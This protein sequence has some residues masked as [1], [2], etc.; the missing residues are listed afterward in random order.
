MPSGKPS[1]K[2][3]ELGD[4]LIFPASPVMSILIISP[5][6]GD[7]TYL[8]KCYCYNNTVREGRDVQHAGFVVSGR[9]HGALLGKENIE[10][11]RHD[12]QFEV[13]SRW[14]GV[15]KRRLFGCS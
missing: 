14:D 3:N 4:A 13:R 15:F 10:G 6:S 9:C 12:K 8:T 11:C 7:V 5:L 1:V 2:P